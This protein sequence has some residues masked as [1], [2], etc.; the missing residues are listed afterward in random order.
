MYIVYTLL[1]Y[2]FKERM[3]NW[4]FRYFT[5]DGVIEVFKVRA[6]ISFLEEKG[7]EGKGREKGRE[8]EIMKFFIVIYFDFELRCSAALTK[9]KSVNGTDY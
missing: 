9:S 6:W 4:I 1:D 3:K 2:V 5:N 8:V 7:R